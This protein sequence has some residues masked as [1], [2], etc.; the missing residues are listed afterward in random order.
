MHARQQ[1]MGRTGMFKHTL[2][3]VCTMP[4]MTY[5]A[6]NL[7]K[8]HACMPPAHVAGRGHD[9]DC[10]LGQVARRLQPP[11]PARRRLP[12][13][14]RPRCDRRKR[15]RGHAHLAGAC[16]VPCMHPSLSCPACEQRLFVHARVTCT[17]PGSHVILRKHALCIHT[18]NKRTESA[19]SPAH[20]CC[21]GWWRPHAA[22]RSRPPPT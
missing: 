5:G 4:T 1:L 19:V 22:Q 12:G 6:L 13:G 7:K 11:P 8:A 17:V 20:Q 14:P 2:L 18:T 21:P 3:G 15:A 16:A 9:A 10:E